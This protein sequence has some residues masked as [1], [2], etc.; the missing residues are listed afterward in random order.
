[1]KRERAQRDRSVVDHRPSLVAQYGRINERGQAI[2]EFALMLPCLML[3]SV[4]V[5][6]VGR[7]IYYTIEVNN[8]AT[9]GVEYGGQG[10]ETE[11]DTPGMQTK[12]MADAINLPSM[13]ASATYGCTCDEGA[14]TSCTYPVPPTSSCAAPKKSDGSDCTSPAHIVTCV[15]VSTQATI[16]PLFNYPGLPSSYV[17]NGKSVM[18]VRN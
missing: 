15:Q 4:G 12:A 16:N 3:L 14:G 8:A 5:I 6:E 2:L 7:A 13:T 18:R 10:Y 17:A 11:T 1:M 9:V